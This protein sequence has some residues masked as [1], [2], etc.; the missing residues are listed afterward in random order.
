VRHWITV[1]CLITFSQFSF[2]IKLVPVIFNTR[3]NS[4]LC[5]PRKNEWT[6]QA[7]GVVYLRSSLFLDFMRRRLTAGYSHFETT[8][9]SHFQESS[10][11]KNC[12]SKDIAWPL[13]TGPIDCTETLVTSCQPTLRGLPEDGSF[14]NIKLILPH[15]IVG[16][17]WLSDLMQGS[18]SDIPTLKTALK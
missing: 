12:R 8:Y 6:Y 7:L 14:Q 17:I 15:S 9:R 18:V 16:L 13:N 1:S 5:T 11:S 10:N 4:I 3:A 2:W